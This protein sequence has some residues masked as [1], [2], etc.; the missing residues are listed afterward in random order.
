MFWR[1]GPE[2]KHTHQRRQSAISRSVACQYITGSDP[3]SNREALIAAVMSGSSVTKMTAQCHA[4]PGDLC[5]AVR[6]VRQRRIRGIAVIRVVW[7][8][9]G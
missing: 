2:S 3:A 6:A 1:R 8:G 9:T 7:Q 5:P 4:E